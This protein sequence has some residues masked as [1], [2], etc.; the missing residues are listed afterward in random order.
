VPQR[1]YKLHLANSD[2]V[3]CPELHHVKI[4]DW[5]TCE[6]NDVGAVSRGR[7]VFTRREI[8]SEASAIPVLTRHVAAVV[9]RVLTGRNPGSC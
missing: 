1:F 6:A 7:P 3:D 4:G 9:S 5:N 8:E 2:L